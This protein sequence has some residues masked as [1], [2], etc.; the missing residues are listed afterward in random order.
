MLEKSL[1][2][3]LKTTKFKESSLIAQM[4]TRNHGMQSFMVSGITS[5]KK[6]TKA[7]LFQ[8]LNQIELVYYFKN[9]NSVMRVKEL[10]LVEPYAELHYNVYKSA[11]ATFLQEMLFK[12]LRQQEQADENM[13]DFISNGIHLLD[14]LDGKYKYFHVHFLVK[15]TKYLGFMPMGRFSEEMPYFDFIEGVFTSKEPLHSNFID[16]KNAKFLDQLIQCPLTQCQSLSSYHG[17]IGT[18]IQRLIELYQVHIQNFGKIKS[19]EV[20]TEVFE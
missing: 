6:Y 11:I 3:V 2:I 14:N 7:A 18:W 9:T 15:L 20:L 5:K 13:F 10:K 4:Y 12:T 16:G 17:E 19:L 1:A 8:P